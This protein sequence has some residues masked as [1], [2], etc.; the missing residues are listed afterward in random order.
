M[1]TRNATKKRTRKKSAKKVRRKAPARKRATRAR[2]ARVLKLDIPYSE[3]GE[4]LEPANARYL[5][6]PRSAPD[7][8]GPCFAA[9]GRDEHSEGDTGAEALRVLEDRVAEIIEYTITEL[10]RNYA[11]GGVA[12]HVERITEAAR[13]LGEVVGYQRGRDETVAQIE[14]L[15]ERAWRDAVAAADR[16]VWS[17]WRLDMAIRSER[18]TV[19]EVAKLVGEDE[20]TVESW[21]RT[22]HE[23]GAGVPDSR[24]L[25]ELANALGRTPSWLLG[26]NVRRP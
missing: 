9:L 1:A 17:G 20:D 8:V 5:L 13:G 25:G 12:Y 16:N 24:Q 26:Q 7:L 22:S 10:G 14:C 11:G 6:V 23:T 4:F 21:T 3:D 18:L 19:A 2:R 15:S